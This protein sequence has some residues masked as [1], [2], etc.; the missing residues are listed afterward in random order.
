MGTLTEQEKQKIRNAAER[1]ANELSVPIHW[2]KA[3]I[4]DSAQAVEDIIDS[5]SFKTA[6]SD[7]ID[8]AA[9]VHSVTFTANE[10]KWIAA[11]VMEV[12]YTRDVIG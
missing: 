11:L 5:T 10:K 9:A 8:T 1:K 7:G 2:V 3:A 6:I 4:G 12:R